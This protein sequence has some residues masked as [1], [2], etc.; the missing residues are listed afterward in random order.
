METD[1]YTIGQIVYDKNGD[2]CKIL[3]KTSNSIEVFIKKK[4][5]KGID[6]ANWFTIKEFEAR[7]A[8]TSTNH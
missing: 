5:D 6:H 8:L 4:T 2:G 1:K 7:F 3:N